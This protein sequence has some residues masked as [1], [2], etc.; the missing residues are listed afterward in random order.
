MAL[1]YT[2]FFYN[3]KTSMFEP[4]TPAGTHMASTNS[5]GLSV[6][7]LAPQLFVRNDNK[8]KGIGVC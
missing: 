2:E 6:S 1:D 5:S 7:L 8:K 3:Y 4:E